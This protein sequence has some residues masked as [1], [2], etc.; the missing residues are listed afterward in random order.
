MFGDDCVMT[1]WIWKASGDIQTRIR[2]YQ[3]AKINKSRQKGFEHTLN[4]P[5][6]SFKGL[7]EKQAKKIRLLVG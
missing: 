7:G 1:V 5:F 4:Y 6:L 3:L 2:R